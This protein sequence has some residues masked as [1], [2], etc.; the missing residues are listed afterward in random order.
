MLN[1]WRWGLVERESAVWVYAAWWSVTAAP[2]FFAD[3]VDCSSSRRIVAMAPGR[4][5]V[6]VCADPQSAQL[7]PVR[8]RL[9]AHAICGMCGRSSRG[10]VGR[11]STTAEDLVATYL[12]ALTASDVDLVIGLFADEG[13]VHSRLYG[14]SA[15]P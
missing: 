11:M 14:T 1:E 2:R 9:R 3:C 8:V 10:S 6:K 5:P 4:S 13:V 15:S 12:R 7:G